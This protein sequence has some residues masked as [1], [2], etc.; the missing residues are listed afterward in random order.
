MLTSEVHS[1]ATGS[2]IGPWR[3][4]ERRGSGTFGIV[5]R[6]CLAEDPEAGGYALKLARE[7]GDLRFEREGELL[8]RIRHP[9]VPG[10]RDRGV[11]HDSQCK[12]YPYLVMQWVEG[13]PLYDWARLRGF[14]S[15]QVLQVLAQLARAL[16]ATH[17]HGVHRDVKGDNVLVTS[18]GHAVLVD[19]GCCRYPGA[20]ELTTGV[21]P[22]GTRAYRSP[23]ALRHEREGDPAE[24]YVG[25][26][27]DDVYA[28]GVTAYYLVTGSY[29]PQGTEGAPRL[30]PPGQLA[31][32]TPELETLI[33]R[34]LSDHPQA[35][36]TAGELAEALEQ[37]EKSTGPA[38]NE[39]VWP[40]RSMLPTERASRPGPT[41]RHLAR[42]ALRRHSKRLAVAGAL[43]A[44]VLAGGLLPLLP[45]L[46][47]KEQPAQLAAVEEEKQAEAD[48]D[49]RT[50]GL[51]DGG[52]NEVLAAAEAQ[53]SHGVP[54]YVM[55]TPLPEKPEPGQKKPPCKSPDQRAIHGGCWAPLATKPPC[56][57][58]YEHD[59]RCYAPVM[60]RTRRQPASEE[61]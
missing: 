13:L 30:L 55:A 41:R 46:A 37:A 6:V 51:A 2:L 7:P 10:L 49:E 9:H 57:D 43:A 31:S 18:E 20:R 61:P 40:S 58:F 25:T 26:A 48:V 42:Q 12:G 8:S 50:V 53:P 27:A 36:G 38:A 17:R 24:R 45:R 29:P 44:G 34:M 15:R 59:G 54:G 4:L 19:F 1:P 39:R 14:T 16:E 21:L 23:Q 56:Q 11:W 60:L 5:Y 52:V 3:V 47:N 35:R 28:L 22:P 32:V 33:L